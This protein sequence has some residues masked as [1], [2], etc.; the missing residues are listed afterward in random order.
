M[1][2]QEAR[3]LVQGWF[4]RAWERRQCADEDSFEPFIFCWIAFNSWGCCVTG[5]END[6]PMVRDLARSEELEVTFSAAVGSQEH[7]L[8]RFGPLFQSLWPIFKVQEFRSRHIY[9]RGPYT[10]RA[11]RIRDYIQQGAEIYAPKI[12]EAP[13]PIGDDIPLT[14]GNALPAIYRVR[15]N[16]FHGEKSVRDEQDQRIVGAA[17]RVLVYAFKEFL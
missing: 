13:I 6:T 10:T 3:E 1:L 2:R 12:D 14:W 15:C 5:K 8:E 17:F 7:P 4:E 16:L 9:E 11:A